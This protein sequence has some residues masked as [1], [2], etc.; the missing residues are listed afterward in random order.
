MPRARQKKL[1]EPILPPV[2]QEETVVP[3]VEVVSPKGSLFED[4]DDDDVALVVKAE[5]ADIGDLPSLDHDLTP[6]E[7]AEFIA[8]INKEL[9]L[10]V[11][12]KQLG[13]LARKTGQKTA[14]V[15]LR[16]IIE[17]NEITG[18][19]KDKATET[20]PMFALPTGT[21]VSVKIE[22]VVK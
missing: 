7:K 20:V 3:E 13:I 18:L 9:P 19:R 16:A 15:G 8:L 17:A 2:A 1:L 6:D 10:A 22:K 12:A 21:S 5:P 4:L 14:A 11:R